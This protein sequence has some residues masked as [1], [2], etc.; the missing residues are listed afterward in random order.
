MKIL[1]IDDNERLTLI[2]QMIISKQGH[3]TEVELKSD[4]ALERTREE[5]PDLI[6]LDIMMEPFSGWEVL[7]QI[8]GDAK[9]SE[10]PIIVLTGKVMTIDEALRYGMQVD[11]FV[12]KP[13]ERSMLV[14][15]V[16]EVGEILAECEI[17]YKRALESGLSE[18]QAAGCRRMIRKRKILIYLKELLIKQERIINLRPEEESEMSGTIEELRK[19]IETKFQDF[20]KKESICP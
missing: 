5:K 11:G 8:R 15:A 17:R 13:L 19:M 18:E 14:T 12:M 10:I 2:Y 4:H 7:E 6:L 1:I 9:L 20:A 3:Q 16:E